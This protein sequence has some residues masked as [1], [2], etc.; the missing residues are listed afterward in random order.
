MTKRI[1]IWAVIIIA[2]TVTAYNVFSRFL[3]TDEQ[4]IRAAIMDCASALE[5]G[6]SL[7]ITYALQANLSDDYRH[8]GELVPV[9]K[10]LATGHILHVA[11]EYQDFE[12][13]I[14]SFKTTIDGDEATVMLAGRITAA[15]KDKPDQRTEVLTSGGHNRC[16]V[17]LRK[18]RGQWEIF[19]S[20]RLEGGPAQD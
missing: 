15:P 20:Q 8:V 2:I 11:S 12:V 5:S 16:E 3:R 6:G 1:M 14:D 18:V 13:K 7:R 4:K 17:R 19:Q 10:D 9:S